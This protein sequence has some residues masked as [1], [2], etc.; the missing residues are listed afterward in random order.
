MDDPHRACVA[1][2]LIVPLG[3]LLQWQLRPGD[4]DS[5]LATS[6]ILLTLLPIAR[7]GRLAMLDGTQLTVMAVLWIGLL[8]L[9]RA[10][11]PAGIGLLTGLDGQRNAAA[12]GPIAIT[13]RCRRPGRRG[14]WAGNGGIGDGSPQLQ[15]C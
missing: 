8:R 6:A 15:H 7:H 1:F 14:T 13:N 10:R 9:H 3:G 2:S 12:E 11:H 5:C 4:R